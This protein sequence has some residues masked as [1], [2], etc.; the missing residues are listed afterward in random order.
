[1][2]D[3]PVEIYWQSGTSAELQS[4]CEEIP[5]NGAQVKHTYWHFTWKNWYWNKILEQ[6]E[7][8]KPNLHLNAICNTIVLLRMTYILFFLDMSWISE[9]SKMHRLCFLIV[10]IL[11][12]GND[13]KIVWTNNMQSLY[14]IDTYIKCMRTVECMLIGKQCLNPKIVGN[15][16][17]PSRTLV[18]LTIVQKFGVQH[19]FLFSFFWKI[20][21]VVKLIKKKW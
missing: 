13:W 20:F 10:F 3:R 15:L 11:A 5:K 9:L 14:I 2:N 21:V 17:I 18:M 12:E 7:T 6:I 19:I 1:M 8:F 16:E 4:V